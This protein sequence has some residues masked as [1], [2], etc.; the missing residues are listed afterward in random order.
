LTQTE[1]V[2]SYSPDVHNRTL[3][4]A[5]WPR[6]PIG[7]F[8]SD[9]TNRDASAGTDRVFDVRNLT[10]LPS[11]NPEHSTP[12]LVSSPPLFHFGAAAFVLAAL[13]KI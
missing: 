6:L 10:G 4:A 7:V 1:V 13:L 3:G 12:A 9:G 2:F 11:R 8:V 5:P